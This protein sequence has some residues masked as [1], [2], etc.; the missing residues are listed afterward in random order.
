MSKWVV[1]LTEQQATLAKIACP[2]GIVPYRE[3]LVK[4]CRGGLTAEMIKRG[5]VVCKTSPMPN[6][7]GD[8]RVK[9]VVTSEGMYVGWRS[10][11]EDLAL[12]EAVSRE[13]FKLQCMMLSS[14]YGIS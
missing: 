13:P 4:V 1:G 2:V 6:T 8:N 7:R 9:E 3:I 5:R 10:G 11:N 14:C 12:L